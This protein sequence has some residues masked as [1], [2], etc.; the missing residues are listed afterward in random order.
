MAGRRAR[1][2]E[3]LN[4]RSTWGTFD[5]LVFSVI[6]GSFGTLQN[7]LYLKKAVCRAKWIEICD[8]W[9][10]VIYMHTGYV[11]P[12][13]IQGHLGDIRFT[14]LKMAGNSKMAGCRARRNEIWESGVFVT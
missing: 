13:S 2:S 5:L 14:C 3:I 6:V 10:V 11:W 4:R 12:V 7:G 8:S 9:V 1:L